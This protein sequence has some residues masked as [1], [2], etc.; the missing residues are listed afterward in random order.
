MGRINPKYKYPI[1]PKC[2]EDAVVQ[3][4]NYRFTVLTDRLIRMEYNEDGVFEDRATQVV[5][6]RLF[7]VPKFSVT[8][9]DGTLKISTEAMV[10]TYT[11][12]EFAPNSL[13]AEF[14]EKCGLRGDLVWYYGDEISF[15]GTA[16]TLDGVNGE[17]ELGN[18]LMSNRRMTVL[19]DSKSL[20]MAEDGWIDTRHSEKDMYLFAYARD[21]RGCLKAFYALTG[22]T[23]ML[24]RYAL[25]NW[26]SRYYRYTQDEYIELMERFKNENIPISVAV[27]DMDWHCDGW[28]GFT[29][30]KELFPD[31]RAFLKEL[32]ERGLEVTLNL[33]PADGIGAHEAQY[34]K[35]AEALGADTSEKKKIDFDIADPKFVENYFSV[36]LHPLEEEGVS[37]WWMDWQQGNTTKIPGLDPL[38][39]LNHYHYTDMTGSDKRAMIF[40]RYSGPGSHRYPVGFSGDTYAT[41]ESLDFQ[42]YFTAC[43]SNIGYG[44]WSHDIGGHMGG[45]RDDEMF[46]RW[47]QFGVFSPIMRLH[48]TNNMFQS[49]EPWNYGLAAYKSTSEFLRLRH[50]LIPYLYT[51]NYKAHSDDAPLVQPLYYGCPADTS[52]LTANR[53]EYF[54]GSEMLVSPVTSKTDR[55]T[56]C[57]V[58]KTYLPEG[59][60]Y[61]F[62]NLRAYRGKRTLNVYRDLYT[63]PV[64]VKAGGIVPTAEAE[65]GIENPKKLNIAV[66]PG[67]D[68]NFS[69][70]ED[71][72]VTMQY[73]NGAYAVTELALKWGEKAEFT[74]KKPCGDDSV[75]I[76]NRTYALE[77]KKLAD[78]D[79]TVKEDGKDI[80]FEKHY[81]NETLYVTVKDINGNVT[82][83]FDGNVLPNDTVNEVQSFILG[84]QCD[85]NLKTDIFNA[86]KYTENPAQAVSDISVLDMDKNLFGALTEIL[87]AE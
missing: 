38:W 65:N 2:H 82:V 56:G 80:P 58:T 35:L 19:D 29:W 53:N 76:K 12:G 1:T 52:A 18:S 3:G 62:F 83:C 14:T 81:E 15:G 54:F 44:W 26:W 69:L 85:N 61:D 17:C 48:S 22:H 36:L 30:N 87:L 47:V 86:V 7:D 79:V 5:V 75:I 46:A 74:I 4:E 25:G 51:M 60:W 64:F 67:A 8:N 33:H 41:W 68:N 49:K 28:T 34:E 50:K 45:Y 21:Y 70:Y 78:C 16:R 27:I 40:S 6:N 24:P 20:I 23:P 32:H 77:F 72:G 43:A 57:A 13:H 9:I 66:F 37:F 55:V 42:P 73:E 63:M 59:T 10:L 11:G 31:H 84:A 39:M 71:D